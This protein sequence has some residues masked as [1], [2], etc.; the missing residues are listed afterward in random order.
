M[1]AQGSKDCTEGEGLVDLRGTSVL[2]AFGRLCFERR[3]LRNYGKASS[4]QFLGVEP[5]IRFKTLLVEAM[6]LSVGR[7]F[8]ARHVRAPPLGGRKVEQK[9]TRSLKPCPRCPAARISDFTA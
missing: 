9:E 2:Q 3:R 1:A 7:G 4:V 8:R 5:W 6:S